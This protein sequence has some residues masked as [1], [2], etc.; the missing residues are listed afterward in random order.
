MLPTNL[1][2]KVKPSHT[3]DLAYLYYLPFCTV[4]TSRD[5]FHVQVA[6]LFMNPFQTF[7]HGDDLK[8]D[9]RR[10]HEIYQQLPQEELDKG[11]IDFANRPPEETSFLTTRLWDKYLPKWREPH[12]PY[13]D[14]P[15]DTQSDSHFKHIPEPPRMISGGGMIDGD[16]AEK[17]YF[18]SYD[19]ER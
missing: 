17:L 4:F 1:L 8:E 10:L 15:Q 19:S 16:L 14:L 9:L 13:T 7:V 6:P 5:K 18:R 12:T 3:I 11:L 2:S